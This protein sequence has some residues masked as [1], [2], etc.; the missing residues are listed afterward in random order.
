MTKSE[1]H[2][3]LRRDWTTKLAAAESNGFRANALH[4]LGIDYM[5]FL[6]AE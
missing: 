5:P 2:I 6:E 4:D 3:K 1:A